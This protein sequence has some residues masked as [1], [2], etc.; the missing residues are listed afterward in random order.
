MGRKAAFFTG[1]SIG[2][3]AGQTNEI[4]K[5][6]LVICQKGFKK[7]DLLKESS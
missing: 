6:S 3:P 1:T 7:A 5:N 2:S 4:I